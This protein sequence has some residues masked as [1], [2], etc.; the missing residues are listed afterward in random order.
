MIQIYFIFYPFK[1]PSLETWP[2]ITKTFGIVAKKHG[3]LLNFSLYSICKWNPKD[4][5]KMHASL[6]Y[7]SSKSF[8]HNEYY[9]ISL[10]YLY[11]LCYIINILSLVKKSYMN[12]NL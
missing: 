1:P 4:T 12:Y 8:C 11:Y 10:M 7:V 3:G 2:S 6:I 5:Y 9:H